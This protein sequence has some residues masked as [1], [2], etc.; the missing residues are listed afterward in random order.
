MSNAIKHSTKWTK[1]LVARRAFELVSFHDAAR[2][3]RWDY[4][5]ACR[6]F[7]SQARVSGYIDKSD[8]KFHLATR[9]QYRVL[10]KARAALYNAQRRLEAAVRHCVERREVT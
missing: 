7:R 2:R 9:K 8:P 10:H 1:D 5:D 4:H 6:E 3:A